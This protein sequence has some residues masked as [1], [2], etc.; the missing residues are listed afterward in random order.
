MADLESRWIALH[1]TEHDWRQA[2]HG[3]QDAERLPLCAPK[4]TFDVVIAGGG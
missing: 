4:N 1:A 2:I 3:V